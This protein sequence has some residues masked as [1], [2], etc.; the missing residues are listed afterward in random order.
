[1][2]VISD[3]Q[4]FTAVNVLE[5]ALTALSRLYMYPAMVFAS[6]ASRG[7]VVSTGVHFWV[8]C[9]AAAP[10][11]SPKGCPDLPQTPSAQMHAEL[12]LWKVVFHANHV[13]WYGR[14]LFHFLHLVS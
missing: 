12:E 1:M 3:K 8:C 6:W 5:L 4:S 10:E 14:R 11:N 9:C 2:A 13:R 7:G